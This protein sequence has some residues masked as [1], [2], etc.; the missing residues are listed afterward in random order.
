MSILVTQ[1]VNGGSQQGIQHNKPNVP[2]NNDPIVPMP[3]HSRGQTRKS[4]IPYM[5][6]TR[7]PKAGP[8]KQGAQQ[9]HEMGLTQ[10]FISPKHVSNNPRIVP[11]ASSSSIIFFKFLIIFSS[12]FIGV[13]IMV[14]YYLLLFF[15]LFSNLFYYSAIHNIHKY[16]QSS[17]EYRDDAS[18]D[19]WTR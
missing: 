1:H 4:I 12:F 6:V 17:L 14:F 5:V 7:H 8:N 19:G 15:A 11:I 13:L 18:L 9:I 2:P 16:R 3:Q 10:K